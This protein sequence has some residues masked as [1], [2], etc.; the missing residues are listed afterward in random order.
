MHWLVLVISALFE[1]VWANALAQIDGLS[2]PAPILVFLFGMTVSMGGLG[3][4][5]RGIPVGTGY[6]VWVG[7][8]AFAT[9]SYAFATGAEAVTVL[10]VLFMVAIVACVIGLKAVSS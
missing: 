6:A 8:G 7:I 5:L 9:A 1:A 2:K 4:A 10:K 3:W